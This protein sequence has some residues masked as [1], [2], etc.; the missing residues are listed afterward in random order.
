MAG[1]GFRVFEGLGCEIR[2]GNRA[3]L[4]SPKTASWQKPGQKRTFCAY[5]CVKFQVMNSNGSAPCQVLSNVS[6]GELKK[7]R[8]ATATSL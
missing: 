2:K 3:E 8:T 6:T 1:A 7:T 5:S 4:I